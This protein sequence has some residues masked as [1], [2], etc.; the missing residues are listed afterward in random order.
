MQIGRKKV[1]EFLVTW[2]GYPLEEAM[3]VPEQNFPFPDELKQMLKQDKPVE[4][5]GGSSRE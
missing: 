3:W 5:K 4:D 1:R 2:H